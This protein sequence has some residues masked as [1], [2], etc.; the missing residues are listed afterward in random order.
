MKKQILTLLL[1]ALVALPVLATDF[2]YA[3]EGQEL[4]YTV[5]DETARTCRVKAGEYRGSGRIISGNSVAGNLVIPQ[6][7]K[8]GK[9]EYTVVSIGQYAFAECELTSVSIPSS[10]TSIGEYAFYNCRELASV[11]IPNSVT[12]IGK[13]AFSGCKSLTS[14]TIPN[15]VT[16]IGV[17]A[18][19]GCEALTS[20]ILPDTITTIPGSLFYGCKWLSRIELPAAVKRIEYN[21]FNACER[22]RSIN[23]PEG[24]VFIGNEAFGDTGLTSITLPSSL[25]SAGNSIFA[26]SPL[27]EVKMPDT[28]FTTLESKKNVFGG[29]PYY[30]EIKVAEVTKRDAATADRDLKRLLG[31]WTMKNGDRT[32]AVYTFNKDHTYTAKYTNYLHSPTGCYWTFTETGTW[33]LDKGLVTPTPKT[34]SRPTVK[35]SPMANWQQK[36]YPSVMAAMTPGEY[37]KFLRDD[38]SA[39][40]NRVFKMKSDSQ[41]DVKNSRL[42]SDYDNTWGTLVKKSGPAK[43]QTS[44]KKSATK[45]RSGSRRR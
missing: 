30:E 14:V 29:T 32:I 44:G 17:G 5:L 36:K 22:L 12:S 16:S 23:L 10:V 34:F 24:V 13:Y 8:M 11:T 40:N 19:Q 26:G 4:N 35:V 28:F 42:T 15:S 41:M 45:K 18:F 2:K 37:S 20:V 6:G 1:G 31:C 7:A 38:V 27:K 9:D 21:A 43:T 33:S 25:E 3:Y 39:S